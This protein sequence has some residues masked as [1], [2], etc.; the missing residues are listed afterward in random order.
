[1][2]LKDKQYK[3]NKIKLNFSY[4]LLLQIHLVRGDQDCTEESTCQPL[5]WYERLTKRLR[6]RE[7]KFNATMMPNKGV[8]PNPNIKKEKK[9]VENN[10]GEYAEEKPSFIL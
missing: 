7:R 1:M 5:Q 10:D 8:G 4:Y 2:V 6:A 3:T 9:D